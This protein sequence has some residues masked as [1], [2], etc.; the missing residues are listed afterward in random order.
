MERRSGW[1]EGKVA[2][3]A[4]GVLIGALV[5]SGPVGA[6]SAQEL[7]LA[8]RVKSLEARLTTLESS[9]SAARATGASIAGRLVD[10]ENA[11]Q[12]LDPDGTYTG[13]V[14]S[15]QVWSHYCEDG[16]DSVWADHEGYVELSCSAGTS[17]AGRAHG[18][19]SGAPSLE[20]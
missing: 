1:I 3:L 12:L 13:Y 8:K 16:D 9:V 11:T 14:N 2:L 20:D 19:P 6:S 17:S 7:R 5:A 4:V 10:V 15:V 18:P